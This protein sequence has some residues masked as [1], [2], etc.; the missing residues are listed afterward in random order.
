M[1]GNAKEAQAIS[2]PMREF[3]KVWKQ[4][5]ESSLVDL[6]VE[7]QVAQNVLIHDV[8]FDSIKSV[9][10]HV[11]FYAVASDRAIKTHVQIVFDGESEAIKSLGGILIKVMHEVEVEALP[12]DLPHEFRVDLAKLKTFQD[13]IVIKDIVAPHGVTVLASPDAVVAK[14][15]APRTTEEMVSLE[16]PAEVSLD[17]IEVEKKGKKEEA[18]AGDESASGE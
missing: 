6:K 8:A 5:G 9:P 11:D 4:A 2:V 16:T 1:Y 18:E 14:V 10:L 17:A 15:N 13:H 12:K 3:L 7:K